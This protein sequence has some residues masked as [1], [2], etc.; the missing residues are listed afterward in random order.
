M[1]QSGPNGHLSTNRIMKMAYARLF[2]ALLVSL[3]VATAAAGQALTGSI[4]GTVT[5]DTGSRVA[6]VVVTVQNQLTGA[7]ETATTD[8]DGKYQLSGLPV[9][10][11]YQVRVALPDFETQTSE[12]VTLVPNAILVVNFRLKLSITGSVEVTTAAPVR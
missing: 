8:A 7:R 6:S 2:A 4:I 5:S 10:G 1:R 12:T 9:D 11:D 3:A